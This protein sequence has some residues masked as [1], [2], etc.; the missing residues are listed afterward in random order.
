MLGIDLA[1]KAGDRRSLCRRKPRRMIEER[2]HAEATSKER[3]E[4][5]GGNVGE[6]KER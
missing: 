6:E 5:C 4:V 3:K 1:V 2:G